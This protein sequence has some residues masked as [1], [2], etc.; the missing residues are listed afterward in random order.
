MLKIEGGQ[1]ENYSE[2]RT[3]NNSFT[4]HGLLK[5]F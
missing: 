1:K 5:K 2:A 3:H 4:Q